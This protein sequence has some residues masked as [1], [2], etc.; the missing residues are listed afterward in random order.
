MG[1]DQE[2]Q[3]SASDGSGALILR[4]A[5]FQAEDV[6]WCASVCLLGAVP[7]FLAGCFCC[8]QEAIH[9]LRDA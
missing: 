7:N 2:A 8:P 5:I 3:V 1:W 9:T 6:T 4:R